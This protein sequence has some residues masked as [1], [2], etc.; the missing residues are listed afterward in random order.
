MLNCN[1]TILN[2]TNCLRNACLYLMQHHTIPYSAITYTVLY[3]TL[4]YSTLRYS[5]LRYTADRLAPSL[6]V[7]SLCR[8]PYRLSCPSAGALA[9]HV[10]PRLDCAEWQHAAGLCEE[11]R[12]LDSGSASSQKGAGGRAAGRR[13]AVWSGAFIICHALHM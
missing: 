6:C 13:C 3:H 4:L 12:P 9:L 11:K 10:R 5:M 7:S 2:F 1:F 8:P